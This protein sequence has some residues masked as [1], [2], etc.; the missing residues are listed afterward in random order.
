MYRIR[1]ADRKQYGPVSAEMVRRWI[2]ERRANGQS[3]AQAEGESQWKPLSEFPEFKDALQTSSPA[4]EG[5]P[6]IPRPLSA[7][8][9]TRTSGIATAS[10]V[11]GILGL[12]TCGL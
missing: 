1:G 11:L 2:A 12:F 10:L 6:P 8:P 4:S 3:L 5:A 9:P 7:M